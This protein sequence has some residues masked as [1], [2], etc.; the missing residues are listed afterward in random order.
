M[1]F[2][3]PF[4]IFCRS[5]IH[6]IGGI[7]YKKR[8]YAEAL[9]LSEE[10]V[11]IHENIDGVNHENTAKALANVGSVTHRLKKMKYCELVERRALKIFMDKYGLDGK[12]VLHLYFMS[13]Y[14]I[15]A[16]Q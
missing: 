16:W 2:D 9:K 4:L 13:Y 3:I 14:F 10:I 7:L 5:Y 8:D 15:V 1:S 6:T 12:E 11:L